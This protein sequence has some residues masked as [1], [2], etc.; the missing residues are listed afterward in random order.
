MLVRFTRPSTLV[1]SV[2]A[3]SKAPALVRLVRGIKIGD[4]SFCVNTQLTSYSSKVGEA[5]YVCQAVEGDVQIIPNTG[6][7]R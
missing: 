5:I 1:R 3:I 4:V 7:V 6:Q 2:L